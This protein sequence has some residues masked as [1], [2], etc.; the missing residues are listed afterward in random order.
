[1]TCKICKSGVKA[2]FV[3][4]LLQKYNVGYYQCEN[5]N[6]IQTDEPFWLDEA[7]K[8]A[9]NHEDIGTSS[10]SL[11]CSETITALFSLC[12]FDRHKKY[13]DYG[14]GYGLFVRMMR[15]SG[16]NFYWYDEYSEN[17][18]ATKFL[19]NDLPK[20]DQNF[21]VVTAF[22]V[23]EHLVDPIKEIEKMLSFSDSILFSTN[24]INRCSDPLENWWYLGV[25]H[26]QHVA[27]YDIKTLIFIAKKFGL[28]L[29]TY[30]NTHFLTKNKISNFKYKIASNYRVARLYNTIF[31]PQSLI[32]SDVSLYLND[33]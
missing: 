32:A 14:A 29:Y 26:G 20:G 21:E 13:L 27:L 25:Q 23:F 16:Y 1:M 31:L 30:K 17:I 19:F 18:F 24:L 33:Y 4:K 8:S 3:K 10:R 6:F 11:I 2:I 12:G 9:I 15:D 28:N 22:E 5:C 7:Y